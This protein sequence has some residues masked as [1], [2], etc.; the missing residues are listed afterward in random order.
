MNYL[1]KKEKSV[2]KASK[3]FK[4]L[5]RAIFT[6]LKTYSNVHRGT[7]HN[8]LITT[9][10]FE[11][12]REIVLE[13]LKLEKGKYF[14]I[15]CS[16]L[17]CN[18]FTTQLESNEYRIIS[19][20]NYGLPLGLR[21][22]A[23]KKKSLRK[24]SVIYT[25]GGMI[26]HVTSNSVEWASLPERF[27]AGTPSI[28]N[29]IALAKAIQLNQNIIDVFQKEQVKLAKQ[30][31]EILY[32]DE[33][34]RYS[35][36]KLLS[37]LKKLLIG[38]YIRV[39]TIDGLKNFINLDNAASTRSFIPI[40]NTYIEIL[41]QAHNLNN[42]IINEV[43][44]ICSRFL[45]APL[46]NYEIIF[47]LN[48]TEA[49]N[50]VA[51]NLAKSLK[52]NIKPVVVNTIMEH[53]SNELP[54]RYIPG[55]N[56][57]RISVNDEGFI[58]LNELENVLQEYNQNKKI[59]T[60]PVQIVTISGVSNVLGTRN[61]LQSISQIVHKY[62][63]KLLVDGAQLVAHHKTDIKNNEIDYFA[64]SGHKIYAPF[65]SG[66]LIVKK[67]LLTFDKTELDRIKSSGEENVVGIATLG[68][69]I[70]L[71]E[72]IGIDVIENYERDL[73]RFALNRLNEI[74]EIEIFGVK[75]ANSMKFSKRGAI[76][77]FNLKNVPHNLAAKE[78]AE[79][80]G[81]GIRNGCFCAHMLIQQILKV[82][83]IRILGARMTS[84][85]IPKKTGMCLP[86]TLRVSFGI[87]NDK[88]DIEILLNIIKKINQKP[89]FMINKLLAQ[90]Y[91]GTL[92]LPKN[93]IEQKIR[94]FID[95]TTKSIFST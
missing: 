95:L 8:S 88:A 1:V 32:Q 12:A 4:E 43:K 84:I 93:R 86:G 61:D 94:S 40:W 87:E 25:G 50:I 73:T 52:K 17:R 13:S 89:R 38:R 9:A 92:F 72:K 45:N 67:G 42:T 27:E 18:I 63:A 44:K 41:T 59:E 7:G 49:I 20:K 56:L 16:P 14:L 21:A 53:H 30:L 51:I 69:A 80:G 47:T 79:Y 31:E 15:F 28:V 66:A 19:S 33:I 37:K 91:N 24:C 22:I 83:Q 77:S 68:K 36:K 70:L 34:F 11:R 39:P 75:S 5:E 64:F 3:A 48:T 78:L 74:K 57:I 6:A 10:L 55:V 60:N 46:E 58:D 65:G 35:G 71:L 29:V 2:S 76:I 85:V 23:I 81:I 26:K 54:F 82:Q 62:G 90:T